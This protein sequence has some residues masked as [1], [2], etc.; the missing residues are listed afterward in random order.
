MTG[1][2]WTLSGNVS[3]LRGE[4]SGY[5][6]G[7]LR[8]GGLPGGIFWG[9]RWTGISEIDTLTDETKA[10]LGHVAIFPAS[11]Y[12]VP[13]EK[14]MEATENILTELEERVTFLRVRISFW[15]PSAYRNGQTLMWR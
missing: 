8:W 4:C 7:I 13:K 6:S 1:T 14:M 11:H 12:V 10:Q 2:I 5:I 15:R 3:G 9:L